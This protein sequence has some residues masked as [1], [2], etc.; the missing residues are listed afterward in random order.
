MT[1]FLMRDNPC[2]LNLLIPTLCN[3]TPALKRHCFSV[4]KSG[5]WERPSFGARRLETS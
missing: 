2:F 5:V 1:V 3:L 4:G